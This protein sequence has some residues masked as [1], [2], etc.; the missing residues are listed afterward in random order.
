M[1]NVVAAVNANLKAIGEVPRLR[2]GSGYYYFDGP[3]LGWPSSSVYVF[4]ADSMS[5][6]EWMDQYRALKREAEAR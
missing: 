2:R 5:V 6:S 3:A 4:R 1:A